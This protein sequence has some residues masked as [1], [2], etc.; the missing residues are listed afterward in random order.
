MPKVIHNFGEIESEMIKVSE[1]VI[2]V[3]SQKILKDFIKDYLL[4]IYKKS[5]KI[6]DNNGTKF[7]EA[8]RWGRIVKTSTAISRDMFY[9]DE[10]TSYNPIAFNDEEP[11]WKNFGIHGSLHWEDSEDVRDLM[12]AIMNE[13]YK[14]SHPM[15]YDRPYKYWDKFIS[16]YVRGGKLKI[17][18]ESVAKIEGLSLK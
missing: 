13:D 15:T 5:P 1:R 3:V 6:Y 16:E 11:R 12:P 14:S 18:I 9:D 10:I 2:D 17:E 4:G 7:Y 8:W